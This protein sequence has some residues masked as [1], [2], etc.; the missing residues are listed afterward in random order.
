MQRSLI[1]EPSVLS[2]ARSPCRWWSSLVNGTVEPWA[3][4]LGATLGIS[5]Y[6]L[7]FVLPV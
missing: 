4:V 2:C 3:R 6:V 5:W 7:P 1:S